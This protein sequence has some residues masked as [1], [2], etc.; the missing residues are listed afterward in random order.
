MIYDD[1]NAGQEDIS[2]EG[3]FE[4]CEGGGDAFHGEDNAGVYSTGR[5]I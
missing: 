1:L 2:E 5:L 3:E 4:E